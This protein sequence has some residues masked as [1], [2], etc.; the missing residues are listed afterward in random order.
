MTIR[1]EIAA[2]DGGAEIMKLVANGTE[3]TIPAEIHGIPVVSLGPRF[4]KDAHGSGN[5]TLIIPASV[6]RASPDAL[7]S[8]SG[9]RAIVYLGSFETFNRF[10]WCPST[11]CQLTCGDGFSFQFLS[12][13]TMAFPDFDDEILSA[14]RRMSEE[15][16]MSRLK[17]PVF[18]TEENRE[19]YERYVRSKLMPMAEHCI[20]ENDTSGLASLIDTGLFSDKELFS[21]LERTVRSGKILSVSAIMSY[22]NNSAKEK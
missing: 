11:D 4:M 18:L 10:K 21:L 2:T 19:K 12:G 16:A 3:I 6:T 8:A 14:N 5:R 15:T 9:L 20:S 17:N 1:A 13:Y 22:I 7:A